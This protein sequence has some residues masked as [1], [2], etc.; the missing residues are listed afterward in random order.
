MR[1]LFPAISLVLAM[2]VLAGC[3][4]E[5]GAGTRDSHLVLPLEE[6]LEHRLALEEFSLH[7]DPGP[8]SGERFVQPGVNV[9]LTRPPRKGAP[10]GLQAH[11][12]GAQ[13][14][15]FPPRLRVRVRGTK[16]DAIQLG[17]RRGMILPIPMWAETPK[18]STR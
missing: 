7:A 13:R 12:L 5:G 8:S 6:A 10:P 14:A 9:P 2:K 15:P 3:G 11:Y 1:L 16:S 17:R 4:I 18:G